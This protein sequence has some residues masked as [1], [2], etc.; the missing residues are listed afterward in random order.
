MEQLCQLAEPPLTPN[1]VLEIVPDV[2]VEQL[3]KLCELQNQWNLSRKEKP[4]ASS[5]DIDKGCLP[6][7]AVSQEQKL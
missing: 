3:G 7:P 4:V 1:E 2:S 5:T 6:V